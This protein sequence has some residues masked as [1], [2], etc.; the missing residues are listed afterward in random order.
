MEH[1]AAMAAH[2]GLEGGR[3]VHVRDGEHPFDVGD[4]GKLDPCG[5]HL[6]KVCHIGHRTPCGKVRQNDLLVVCRE[7][8]CRFGHEVHPAEDDEF[9]C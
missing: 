8:V 4:L 7:D 2:E 9:C 5:F 3:G 1:G 6:V